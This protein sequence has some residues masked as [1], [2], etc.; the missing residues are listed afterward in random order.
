[1]KNFRWVVEFEV[2]E[3]WVADGFNLTDESAK[4]MIENTLPYSYGFET[5]AK[6]IQAPDPHEIMK[7]QGEEEKVET[8]I[9]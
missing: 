9:S 8:A 3:S 6:V 4:D 7:V 1:M 5:T 2:D